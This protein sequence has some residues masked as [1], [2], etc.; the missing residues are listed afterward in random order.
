MRVIAPMT[1]HFFLFEKISPFP[2]SFFLKGITSPGFVMAKIS[3]GASM[4][5]N[6]YF[7]NEMVVMPG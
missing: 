4:F 6:V 2:W 3:T 1:I 5:L 7:P